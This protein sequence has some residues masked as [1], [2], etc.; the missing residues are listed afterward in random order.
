MVLSCVCGGRRATAKSLNPQPDVLAVGANDRQIQ[1][2]D[3]DLGWIPVYRGAV[4]A[5]NVD[6]GREN[7]FVGWQVAAVGLLRHD[8]ERPMLARATNNDRNLPSGP[9]IARRLRQVQ[10]LPGIGPG[11]RCP[12]CP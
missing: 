10:I 9:R 6:L 4:A 12:E 1:D 5:Q 2:G 3:L 11:A 8:L 7:P